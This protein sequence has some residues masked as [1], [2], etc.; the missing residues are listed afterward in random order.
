MWTSAGPQGP[1]K[2]TVRSSDLS[3]TCNFLGVVAADK[4]TLPGINTVSLHVRL[5]HLSTSAPQHLS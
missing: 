1:A 5:K 2:L 3:R 4:V